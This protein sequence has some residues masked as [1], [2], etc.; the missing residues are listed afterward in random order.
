MIVLKK[1]MLVKVDL[2]CYGSS[3]F[4]KEV[5]WPS[6]IKIGSVSHRD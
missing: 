1:K 4:V 2:F 6:Q 5:F 3:E